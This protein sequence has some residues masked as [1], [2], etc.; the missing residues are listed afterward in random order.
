MKYSLLLI[1][2]VMP[3]SLV[4]M[5]KEALQEDSSSYE[6]CK[7]AIQCAV[8]GGVRKVRKTIIMEKMRKI[9]RAVYEGNERKKAEIRR[10]SAEESCTITAGKEDNFVYCC[11]CLNISAVALS[12]SLGGPLGVCCCYGP[13]CCLGSLFAYEWFELAKQEN[14]AQKAVVAQKMKKD[15]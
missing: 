4:C 14:L 13:C 10:I 5:E 8:E 15:D 9:V 6:R 2:F 1:L 7:G 11:G 12:H 3:A